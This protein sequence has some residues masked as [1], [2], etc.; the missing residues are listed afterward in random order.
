MQIG[1]IGLNHK[2]ARVDIREALNRVALHHFS[3]EH[4][5][6]LLTTCNRTEIYFTSEDLAETQSYIFNL[7][8]MRSTV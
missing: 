5:F 7:L 4:P 6:I 8:K 2:Q 3:L 1:V